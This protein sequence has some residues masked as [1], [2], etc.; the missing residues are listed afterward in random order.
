[1]EPSRPV[2]RL[3]LAVPPVGVAVAAAAIGW[4]AARVTP[5]LGFAFDG[6]RTAAL[7]LLA[8]GGLVGALGVAAFYRA[9]TTVDPTRPERAS[10]LVTSGIY[11]VTRNPM[12]VGL[13]VGLLGWTMGLAHPGGLLGAAL[14]VWWMDRFQIRPEER[15]MRRQFG[16][17]F[18]AYAESVR[19]W[20]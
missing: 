14:F 17:A 15:A 3:E 9:G 11:R 18:D 19:R 12:Y 5:G 4:G 16:A 13:A 10:H 20:V 6:H 1:L 7:L 2:K 8:L